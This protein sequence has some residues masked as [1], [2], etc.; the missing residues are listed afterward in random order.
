[1]T[2][3]KPVDFSPLRVRIAFS[4][5]GGAWLTIFGLHRLTSSA[6]GFSWAATV[7]IIVARRMDAAIASRPMQRIR[8]QDCPDSQ[9]VRNLLGR[10]SRPGRRTRNLEPLV[11]VY[12]TQ[13][14]IRLDAG[15]DEKW[16]GLYTGVV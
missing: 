16:C 2:A 8:H 12:G 5:G 6:F 11:G 10:A 9:F 4:L 15:F 1:M 13:I 3:E 7:G 14:D